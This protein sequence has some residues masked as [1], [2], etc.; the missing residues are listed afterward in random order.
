MMDRLVIKSSS[1]LFLFLFLVFSYTTEAQVRGYR[2]NPSEFKKLKVRT[3]K[4][5]KKITRMPKFNL[6][7]V[8]QEEQDNL[9]SVAPRFG[10][11]FKVD[12][13]LKDGQWENV[14]GGRLWT[15]G[16]SSENAYSINLIFNE[17]YLPKGAEFYMYNDENTMLY[18][19][20]TFS[21]NRKN[22]R[23]S[24]DLIKGASITL[25]LF[26]PTEVQGQT[27]ISVEREN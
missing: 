8:L 2:T 24:T 16:I 4:K 17:F 14:E 26:E 12:L 18:G 13:K 6:A 15:L 25:E 21:D 9:S 23:L 5:D 11:G 7:Q 1:F 10:K 22:G 19:P 3:P 20:Y 27:K